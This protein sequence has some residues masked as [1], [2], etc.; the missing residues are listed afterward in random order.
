MFWE[1]FS[2]LCAKAGV[3]PNYVVKELGI[4][5][6]GTVSAWKK[7]AIPRIATLDKIAGY[8]GI[9]V[10]ELT[11]NLSDKEIK[12]TLRYESELERKCSVEFT[13]LSSE[14]EVSLRAFY[15]GLIAARK[16]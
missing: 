5:S 8:F 6:T 2:Y 4:K 9:T 16:P 1:N 15:A 13:G 7:G 12:P 10:S 14:E 11:G 3:S